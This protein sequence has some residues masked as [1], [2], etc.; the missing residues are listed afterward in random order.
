M[1]IYNQSSRDSSYSLANARDS[2]DDDLTKRET[3]VDVRTRWLISV[4]QVGLSRQ[5]ARFSSIVAKAFQKSYSTLLTSAAEEK[6][7]SATQIPVQTKQN[8]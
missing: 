1:I 6:A 2:N 5:L 7:Q 4:F 8:A 3:S